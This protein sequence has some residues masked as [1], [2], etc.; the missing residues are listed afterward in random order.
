MYPNAGAVCG[1][2]L[3]QRGICSH[4]MVQVHRFH[5]CGDHRVRSR[6]VLP[7]VGGC[8]YWQRMPKKKAGALRRAWELKRGR[9]ETL[10]GPAKR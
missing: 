3:A 10:P 1:V 7:V 5:V 6:V 8:P 4:A 9:E 2:R